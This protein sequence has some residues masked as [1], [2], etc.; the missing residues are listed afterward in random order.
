MSLLNFDNF[1]GGGPIEQ[2]WGY[3]L[4]AVLS[5]GTGIGGT[6]SLRTTT[7]KTGDLNNG[8]YEGFASQSRTGTKGVWANFTVAGASDSAV[9]EVWQGNPFVGVR[10]SGTSLVL[11]TVNAGTLAT[12]TSAITPGTFKRVELQWRVSSLDAGNALNF[13]GFVE[14]RINEVVVASHDG[15]QLGFAIPVGDVRDVFWNVVVF[16]PHG[17]G[18]KTYLTDASGDVNTGYMPANV[19]I[20][21]VAAVPGNG[22]YTELTPSSGTDQGAMLDDTV[23]DDSGTYL[24]MEGSAQKS[25]WNHGAFSSIGTQLAYGL[26]QSAYGRKMEAG[27]RRFRPMMVRDGIPQ[28]ASRDY[29]VG[30]GYFNWMQHVW[31]VDP[32]TGYK[33]TIVNINGSEFGVLIG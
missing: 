25:A 3:V 15:I 13:D 6:Y 14:L 23:S 20:Y 31:E 2:D 33:W 8:V 22:T 30:I 32:R 29:P 28:Y 24:G 26:K 7:A 11:W 5:A 18:D 1:G 19:N 21:N 12:V 27:Y 10:P 16:N 9:I 17:D 4:G